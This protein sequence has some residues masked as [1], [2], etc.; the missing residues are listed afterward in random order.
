M[1]FYNPTN[2]FL[3]V[4]DYNRCFQNLEEWSICYI[5]KCRCINMWNLKSQFFRNYL[6]IFYVVLKTNILL[7]FKIN[8]F[9]RTLVWYSYFWKL[10]C[11]PTHFSIFSKFV[12]NFFEIFKSFLNFFPTTVESI[13][14]NV[15]SWFAKVISTKFQNQ[16]FSKMLITLYLASSVFLLSTIESTI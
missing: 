3:L 11:N 13:F 12:R 6:L 1:K 15:C 9:S 14:L 8:H 4:I 10:V 16:R 5:C 2:F 7:I